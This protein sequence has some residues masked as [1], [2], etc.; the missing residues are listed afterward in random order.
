M[1]FC[2]LS[3]FFSN[4]DSFYLFYLYLS[5]LSLFLNLSFPYLCHLSHEILYQL[6]GKA[7]QNKYV[8]VEQNR[9]RVK[10]HN[11][12]PIMEYY[13]LS[14]KKITYRFKFYDHTSN[15]SLAQSRFCSWTTH[16]HHH[17]PPFEKI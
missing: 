12:T 7:S 2:C 6:Q 11:C 13:Y 16:P 15:H 4:I 1:I 3:F 17:Q 8:I 9:N 10:P 5:H 14:N